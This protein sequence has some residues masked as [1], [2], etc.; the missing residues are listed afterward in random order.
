M[1]YLEAWSQPGALTAMVNYYRA[2][3]SLPSTAAIHVPTL[4]IWGEQDTAL[5]PGN[6]NG[7]E[8]VVPGITIQRVPDG[9]HWL[10]HEHPAIVNA[11][12]RQFITD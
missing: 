10:V 2:P 7:I 5:L 6:L 4:L 9:S 1:A 3:S 11:A 12:I 8:N